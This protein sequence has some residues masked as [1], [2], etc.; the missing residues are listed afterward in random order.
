M[1][2]KMASNS[3]GSVTRLNSI[4]P[5]FSRSLRRRLL[6]FLA[7]EAALSEPSPNRTSG[8][9][10]GAGRSAAGLPG[11]WPRRSG[12][13]GRGSGRSAGRRGTRRRTPRPRCQG[14]ASPEAGVETQAWY[15]AWIPPAT[16]SVWPDSRPR[17]GN[18]GA[19]RPWSAP[20]PGH[21]PT[22]RATGPAPART[23]GGRWR[24]TPGR[25]R[26]PWKP[27][28]RGTA[29][30]RAAHSARKPASERRRSA[31]GPRAIWMFDALLGPAPFVGGTPGR[32]GR[33]CRPGSSSRAP[34]A[35]VG[36]PPM[37]GGRRARRARAAGAGAAARRRSV[38][39]SSSPR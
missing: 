32:C 31:S 26:C 20:T 25:S 33:R 6:L 29:A 27:S 19:R 12:R 38:G 36:R 28:P 17:H 34:A 5:I 24:T 4:P 8:R 30:D 7:R 21:R 1:S 10:C 13:R 18:A 3:A 22:R 2:S 9:R 11:R 23:G 16:I 35:R 37:P 39:G 14:K 15:S